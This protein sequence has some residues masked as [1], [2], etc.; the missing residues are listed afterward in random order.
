MS[1]GPLGPKEVDGRLVPPGKG[2]TSDYCLTAQ[3]A[4]EM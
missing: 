4:Q 2:S 3:H 1:T